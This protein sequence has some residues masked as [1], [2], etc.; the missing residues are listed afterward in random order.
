MDARKQGCD[1]V[2]HGLGAYLGQSGQTAKETSP[3]T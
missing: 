1:N 2:S 3:P